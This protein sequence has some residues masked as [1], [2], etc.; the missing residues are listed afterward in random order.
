M[1]FKLHPAQWIVTLSALV[2]LLLTTVVGAQQKSMTIEEL[3][4][5]IQEQ[6]ATL[7]EAIANRDETE[8]QARE[9]R[10]ALAEQEARK[11]LAEKELD[12]LCKEQEELKPGTYDDC[13]VGSDR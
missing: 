5:Y 6:K 9:I 13:K 3:E 7:E 2:L 10:D 12:M 8:K 4:S 11:A 1:K